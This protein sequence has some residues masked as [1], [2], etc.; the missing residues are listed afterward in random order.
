MK[1]IILLFLIVPLLSFAQEIRTNKIFESISAAKAAY[2]DFQ[3][4]E[5]FN[6]QTRNAADNYSQAVSDGVLFTIDQGTFNE[7]LIQDPKQIHL[8]IPFKLNGETIALD[9]IQVD[10]FAPGFR[11]YTDA[12]QDITHE[13]DFGKHYRGVVAGDDN[14]LVSISVF[15]SQISG[16][17]ATEEGNFNI[18][19]VRDSEVDHIIYRDTDLNDDYEFICATEDDG[20]GYTEEQISSP[21]SMDPGDEVDIY[22]EAGQS[23]YN[24]HGG[25]LANTVAF[26]TSLFAQSYVLYANDGILAR[27]SNMLIWVNPDPYDGSNSSLQ[28][29]KFHNQTDFLNGDLGHLVEMQ[30]YGGIASGFN[31]IC[32][33]NTDESLCYSGLAGTNVPPVPIYSW[34]VMVITHEMGHLMGSRHTHAC[35]WNGDN[36]AIDG[37]PGYTEG[38]CPVP[39]IPAEGG[40]IMSYCH[41]TGVGINFNLGFGPQPTAV[42]LNNIE[43]TGNCLDEEGSLNPPVAV[44]KT[45]IVY[46]DNNGEATIIVDDVEGGSYDDDGIVSMSIDINTFDCED[47]GMNT[48]T[49]TVTDTDGLTSTCIAYVEVIDDSEPVI[50][51]PDDMTVGVPEGTEYELPDHQDDIV[52]TTDICD[53]NLAATS[54]SPSPGTLLPVGVHEIEL[55]ALLDSGDVLSCTFEITVEEILGT[56]DSILLNSLILYP[57]PAVE[58]LYLSNPE[59][60]EL[61][62]IEI[63]D[64]TGRLI[65]SVD[66]EDMGIEKSIDVSDLSQSNYFAV[67]QG[68]QGKL[69][70]HLIK[71]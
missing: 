39:P 19:K 10:V 61:E 7:F 27:T 57:N 48:V 29:T 60:L 24:V 13:V 69:V 53:V 9:L 64:V 49:L 5:F 65:K 68:A 32:P 16:F 67:I 41:L 46:L 36:T 66:L 63:Y 8:S 2:G 51:C 56:A 1:K 43:A 28:L 33:T 20:V 23:V 54:Q 50:T 18:G 35:V 3:S 6:P 59:N 25:D 34:N 38:G 15:D 14:S 26:L 22:I 42:I 37:C 17:I 40:T 21:N 44:C 30:N 47:V 52:V 58:T 62:S 55:S 45:H 71:N 4:V 70:K 31:G 12:G 11:A